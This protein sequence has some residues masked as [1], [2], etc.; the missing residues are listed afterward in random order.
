VEDVETAAQIPGCLVREL[1]GVFRGLGHVHADNDMGEVGPAGI[2]GPVDD[3]NRRSRGFG[4]LPQGVPRH[5]P[6]LGYGHVLVLGVGPQDHDIGIVVPRSAQDLPGRPASDQLDAPVAIALHL[7]VV[8][9]LQLFLHPLPIVLADL[10]FLAGS[11]VAD[12]LAVTV[13][14]QAEHM[15]ECQMGLMHPGQIE[16][17]LGR[18][19]AGRRTGCGE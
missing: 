11:H 13:G 19:V 10:L 4:H 7:Q 15:E 5:C 3:E 9:I 12:E 2:T 8:G 6:V 16:G 1:E 18:V 17:D 14:G